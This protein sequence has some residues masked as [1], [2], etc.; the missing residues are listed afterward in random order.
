VAPQVAPE[1]KNRNLDLFDLV[2]ICAKRWYIFLPLFLLSTGYAYH[3]YTSVQPLYYANSVVSIAPPNQRASYSSSPM[4]VNGLLEAGGPTLITNLAVIAGSDPGFKL[5]VA[6]LGGTTNFTVKNFPQPVGVQVP[7]PL[8]M[9]ET[10]TGDLTT[11]TKT[12]EIASSQ[13]DGVFRDVQKSAGVADSQLARAI[14][15]SPPRT[16]KATPSR[17][18]ATA[19]IFFGGLGVSVIASV[20]ADVFANRVLGNSRV[21]GRSRLLGKKAPEPLET[22]EEPQAVSLT[23]GP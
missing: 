3:A 15:A 23:T 13:I 20:I 19:G 5:K 21:L 1:E 9:I 8:I 10:T 11:A 17:T 16:A 14:V 18:R 4:E 7:L 2:R 12:I 22:E 6:G